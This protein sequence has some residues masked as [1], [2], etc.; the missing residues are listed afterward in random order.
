MHMTL[1]RFAQSLGGCSLDSLSHF[2]FNG[3]IKLLQNLHS[4]GSMK[5]HFYIWEPR[6]GYL[7]KVK[8]VSWCPLIE[9]GHCL[10]IILENVL[11][12]PCSIVPG[13][14]NPPPPPHHHHHKKSH[15]KIPISKNLIKIPSYSKVAQYPQL[16]YYFVYNCKAWQ[17]FT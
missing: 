2:P 5:Q 7:L 12:S 1:P 15:T 14:I 6:C 10:A 8:K 11:V 3:S 17:R 16:L 9:E 13:A 4:R